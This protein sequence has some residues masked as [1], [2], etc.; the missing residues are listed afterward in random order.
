MMMDGGVM[1]VFHSGILSVGVLLSSV[2]FAEGRR[3]ADPSCG[4][5]TDHHCE[6][7]AAKYRMD[8]RLDLA[9]QMDKKGC[10][11]GQADSCHQVYFGAKRTGGE[12]SAIEEAEK[13]LV[14]RCAMDDEICY[15][16]AIL[17]YEEGNRPRA[18]ELDKK[19]FEK[20]GN[21]S[22]P[23]E[24]YKEGKK[25]EAYA[26]S[27]KAC[28]REQSRC[29]F[30][31]RQFPHHRDLNTLLRLAEDNCYKPVGLSF[32]KTPCTVLGSHYYENKNEKKAKSLWKLEC[33]RGIS[34][35]CLL[36]LGSNFSKA[37][38]SEAYSKFCKSSDFLKY[39]I[40]VVHAKVCESEPTQL[41]FD[42]A[43]EFGQ[44]LLGEYLRVKSAVRE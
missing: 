2:L 20:Y 32:G 35:A 12:K 31:I 10:R 26:L 15:D 8:G 39:G 27:L 11:L 40:D 6:E 17:Y 44:G 34:E 38:K 41:Q 16:L 5:G 25:A 23:L 36:I 42:E 13:I 21:G 7:L 18:L 19:Y 30:W 9:F 29:S 37:D 43:I 1:T 22:Y 24:A 4:A 14:E 33:E 28:Q 3:P